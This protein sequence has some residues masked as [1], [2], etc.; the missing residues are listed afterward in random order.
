MADKKVLVADSITVGEL[1]ETLHLQVSTLVGEL[2]KNGIVATINQ[3]IDFDTAQIIVEEL[4]IDVVLERKKPVEIVRVKHE[5]SDKA[6]P[7]PPIVAVM[8][9]VDHGKTTLLDQILKMHKVLKAIRNGFSHSDGFER[10]EITDLDK[11]MRCYLKALKN[12]V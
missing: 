10:P 5:N 4:G 1:A 3:K 2:F 6:E 12:L 9:H 11:Y 7:R 8:G